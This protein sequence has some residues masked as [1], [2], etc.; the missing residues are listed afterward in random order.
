MR[1]N[2]AVEYME[3]ESR[4]LECIVVALFSV[5][6]SSTSILITRFGTFTNQNSYEAD[7]QR[8]L[9]RNSAWRKLI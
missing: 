7:Q 8:V 6:L 9:S 5:V 1:R 4:D 3:S 2:V